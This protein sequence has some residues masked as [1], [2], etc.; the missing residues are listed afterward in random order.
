M[1]IYALSSLRVICL[2][3]TATAMVGIVA[4]PVLAADI[5]LRLAHGLPSKHV[6]QFAGEYFAKRMAEETKGQVEIKVYPT[7]QLG[8][9]KELGDALR[10][11]NVDFAFTGQANVTPFVPEFGVL[12]A[13]YLFGGFE[14]FQRVVNDDQFNAMIDKLVA[15]RKTGFT[16]ISTSTS[17]VRNFYNIKRLISSP[18]DI[19][20]FKMRVMSSPIEARVWGEIMGALPVA[21]PIGEVYTSMQTGLVHAYEGPLGTFYTGKMYEVAPYVALTEHQW[22]TNFQWVSDKTLAKLPEGVKAAVFAVGK[23][24]ADFAGNKVAADD[25]KI[26]KILKEKYGVKVAKV[27]KASFRDRVA[28]LQNE[29]AKKHGTIAILERIRA[30]Q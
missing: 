25:L 12:S 7:A 23:E 10:Q 24:I 28:P 14:H 26:V 11:G 27:N 19:K 6:F 30:L 8:H 1:S 9:E 17:G 21:I 15:K 3:V 22:A 16:R 20:G 13:K 18:G 2:A 5:T 29:V 4:G